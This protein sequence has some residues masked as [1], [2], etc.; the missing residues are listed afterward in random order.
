MY[1]VRSAFVKCRADIIIEGPRSPELCVKRTA[2][3]YH[4][5]LK[6]KF[7]WK[8][9]DIGLEKPSQTRNCS[10]TGLIEVEANC[11]SVVGAK[12]IYDNVVPTA[13]MRFK[14]NLKESVKNRCWIEREKI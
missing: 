4:R 6:Y 10:R 3:K 2:Q 8:L 14:S 7:P 13:A 9:M 12:N 1:G 5:G 11:G